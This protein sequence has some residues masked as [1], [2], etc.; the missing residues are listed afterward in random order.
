MMKRLLRD[1]DG[2][3]LAGL[4]V[5]LALLLPLAVFGA[6]AL[7]QT[8]ASV[9]EY[10]HH[11][12]GSAEHQDSSAAEYQYSIRVC[13]YTRSKKHPWHIIQ[14]SSRAWPAH[15]RRG[16]VLLTDPNATSCPA[17]GVVWHK[18][19]KGHAYGKGHDHGA[20]SNASSYGKGKDHGNGQGGGNGHHGNGD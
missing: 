12:S 8:A 2:R 15:E 20:S 9:S 14:I 4:A 17:R 6:P 13:H 16:D 7:A 3:I 18:H 10:G 5:T 1:T 19:G 11:H